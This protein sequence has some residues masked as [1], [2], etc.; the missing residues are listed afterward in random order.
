MSLSE[1]GEISEMA[2]LFVLAITDENLRRL[3]RKEL[4][5]ALMADKIVSLCDI[6]KVQGILRET[7][8]HLLG[9]YQTKLEED[10]LLF[11][12]PHATTPKIALQYRITEKRQLMLLTNWR[13]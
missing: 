9:K 5:A 13:V 11:A 6:K 1:S 12:D 2:L 7:A 3:S 8:E 4:F 10:L